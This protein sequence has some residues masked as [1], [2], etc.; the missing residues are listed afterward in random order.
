MAHD[1]RAR[2]RGIALEH[3][4]VVGQRARAIRRPRAT[5]RAR[6]RESAGIHGLLGIHEARPASQARAVRVAGDCRSRRVEIL[7][8]PWRE[9][10]GVAGGGD[11]RERGAFT[12]EWHR[13]SEHDV[14][15]RY[16]REFRLEDDAERSLTANEPIHLVL[17]QRVT[18]RVLL[19]LLPP[20][21]EDP[22]ISERDAKSADVPACRSVPQRPR[23]RRIAGDR[24]TDRRFRLARGIRCP[25]Q[26]RRSHRV[27]D[28]GDERARLDARDA[29]H[30]VDVHD[31]VAA[32][33]RQEHATI[34]DG[35]AG[36]A[37]LRPRH[38]HRDALRSGGA[39]D[40]SDIPL[41]PWPRH[42]IGHHVEPVM[43]PSHMRGAPRGPP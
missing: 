37:T 3:L 4:D 29:R 21:I 43:H 19:H 40:L 33:H 25:G 20:H 39:Q 28:V 9:P 42:R 16:Q 23:S 2:E 8:A 6:R 18:G 17:R 12:V 7:D 41:V 38:R 35:R 1:P 11:E 24:A 32:T 36:G 15:T 10:R 34:R 31:P 22:A 30:R 13:E 14:R 27:L 5:H 26:S